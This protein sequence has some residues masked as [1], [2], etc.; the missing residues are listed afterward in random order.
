MGNEKTKFKNELCVDIDT[1][2][3][4]VVHISKPDHIEQ[5]ENNAQAAGM[6]IDDLYTLAE[7]MAVLIQ[8]AD[9]SGYKSKEKSLEDITNHLK[10]SVN[11]YET[12]KVNS[13][14]EDNTKES[15][16][17]DGSDD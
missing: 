8:V 12:V 9:K 1:S 5:P 17:K 13:E 7:A 14:E 4:D 10:E 6:V 11:S 16:E 2:R 3:E 15:K